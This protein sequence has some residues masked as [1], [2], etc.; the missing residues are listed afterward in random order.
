MGV[1]AC[2]IFFFTYHV[3]KCTLGLVF[4]AQIVTYSE[5]SKSNENITFENAVV[6]GVPTRPVTIQDSLPDSALP[7]T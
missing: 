3:V 5:L 6:P 7:I 1:S 2:I 4:I